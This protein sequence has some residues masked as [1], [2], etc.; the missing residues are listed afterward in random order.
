MGWSDFLD[1]LTLPDSMIRNVARGEFGSAA[2][3]LGDF[4]LQPLDVLPGDVIPDLTGEEDRASS[5]DVLQAWGVGDPGAAAG[6][7]L[8]VAS[9]PWLWAGKRFLPLA[10]TAA[11]KAIPDSMAASFRRAV[12]N[13]RLS[14]PV[15]AISRKAQGASGAQAAALRAY[16]EK[17]LANYSGPIQEAAWMAMKRLKIQPDGKL[18]LTKQQRTF[19]TMEAD[20]AEALAHAEE[21]A[22]ARNLPVEEVKEAVGKYVDFYHDR[23]REGRGTVF[24]SPTGL[25]KDND[26]VTTEEIAARQ[27]EIEG[28]VAAKSSARRDMLKALSDDPRARELKTRL[29]ALRAEQKQIRSD[30]KA[31]PKPSKAEQDIG[32][33]D[34]EYIALTARLEKIEAERAALRAERE[35]FRATYLGRPYEMLSEEIAALRKRN[36]RRELIDKGYAEADL[37]ENMVPAGYAPTAR[38]DKLDET[39]R[40]YRPGAKAN[41]DFDIAE[42]LNDPDVPQSVKDQFVMRADQATAEY[43]PRYTTA[44]ERGTAG[45]GALRMLGDEAAEAFTAWGMNPEDTKSPRREPIKALEDA[46]ASGKVRLAEDDIHHLRT[47][48]EGLP[49]R[50]KAMEIINKL[51]GPF[52]SAAVQGFL[53]PRI[54]G[55]VLNRF[56]T[57]W[58]ALGAPGVPKGATMNQLKYAFPDIVASALSDGYGWKAAN[59]TRFVKGMQV[60]DDAIIEARGS[61]A[62][63][64]TIL[65]K[66]GTPEAKLMAEALDSGMLSQGYISTEELVRDLAG[67]AQRKGSARWFAR[68]PARVFQ[69]SEQY[70]RLGLFTDLLADGMSAEKAAAKVNETM[71]NYRM[72]GP[73]NR[74]IRDIFPFSQ[75]TMQA[76]VR[77]LPKISRHPWTIPLLASVTGQDDDDGVLPDYLADM[78][79]IK[80]GDRAIHGVGSPIESLFSL[81]N[82][83]GSMPGEELLTGVVNRITPVVKGPLE[84]AFNRSSFTGDPFFEHA[85]N[86][87]TGE[88][89]AFGRAVK[90]AHATGISYPVTGPLTSMERMARKPLESLFETVTPIRSTRVDPLYAEMDNIRNQ[91]EANPNVR[92]APIYYQRKGMETPDVEALIDRLEQLQKGRKERAASVGL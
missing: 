50:S 4:F 29:A 25:L 10:L 40:A 60:L 56:S 75:F 35:A 34:P 69:A 21:I 68:A 62:R 24:S 30:L 2:R 58:Q 19:S 73:A 85:P 26:F 79:H 9:S 28:L 63:A 77:E 27:K 1:W 61:A 55:T 82:F 16:L 8:D 47:L 46:V 65:R 44:V 92:Q 7:A 32:A 12:G 36:A 42:F 22:R 59:K 52:R 64:S 5:R 83:S 90:A 20:K 91:L 71:Y 39:L 6:A 3:N 41:K 78:P 49:P 51:T 86:P 31:I 81:P 88:T 18:A 11:R 87:F 33:V 89:D 74:L 67:Q 54:A 45:K 23:F 17:N 37:P 43:I 84:I 14:E 72:S 66:M 53:I 38:R 80:V 15:Q 13:E 48:I 57:I 70:A 76:L